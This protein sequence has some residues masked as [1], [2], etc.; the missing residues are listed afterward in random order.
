MTIL[1][2]RLDDVDA[3]IADMISEININASS[4]SE[5]LS[6][7]AESVGYTLSESMYDIWSNSTGTI[8]NVLEMYQRS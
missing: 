5:T 3:L 6:A 8:S 4:I 7:K 2:Q 1:N